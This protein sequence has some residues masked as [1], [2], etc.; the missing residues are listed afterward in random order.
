METMLINTGCSAKVRESPSHTRNTNR[1][2]AF[3]QLT[4]TP[5]EPTKS[6]IF[7]LNKNPQHKKHPKVE[8]LQV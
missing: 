6:I 5:L 3:H 8:D 1:T 2:Q 4:R 7:Q